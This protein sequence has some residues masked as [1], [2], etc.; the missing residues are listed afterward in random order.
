MAPVSVLVGGADNRM[1]AGEVNTSAVEVEMVFR[2]CHTNHHYNAVP[3]YQVQMQCNACHS[4]RGSEGDGVDKCPRQLSFDSNLCFSSSSFFFFFF[5]A[6]L[7]DESQGQSSIRKHT[8]QD[9]I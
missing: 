3:M 1:G 5:L 7:T 9:R 6:S 2:A 8:E 4:E